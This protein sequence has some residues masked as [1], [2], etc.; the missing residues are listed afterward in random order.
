MGAAGSWFLFLTTQSMAAMTWV[1]S[2]APFEVPT[3][4]EVTFAL[5]ARPTVPVAVSLAIMM[6]AMCVPCP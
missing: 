5:G 2:T 3:L 1:T 4:I 6:P